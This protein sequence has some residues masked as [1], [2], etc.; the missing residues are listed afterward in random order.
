M[1]SK[2]R[3]PTGRRAHNC[4]ELANPTMV[5]QSYA[6]ANRSSDHIA[7]DKNNLK[8]TMGQSLPASSTQSDVPPCLQDI[9]ESYTMQGISTA[10]TNIIV[11]SW[12]PSTGKLYKHFIGR[13]KACCN[14]KQIDCIR[15][16]I[17]QAL[18]FLATLFE[19]GIGYS[20]INTAR[21]ALFCLIEPIDNRAF[22]CHPTV[23]RFMKGIYQ[24]RSP[25][26]R[27]DHIWDVS[28]VLD[29]LK[30]L[31]PLK[32]LTMLIALVS[33]QC[34]QSIHLLSID[35]M[36]ETNGLV[37]FTITEHIKQSRPGY[38][39]P[40]VKLQAFPE[41]PD[42]CVVS[43]L[44]E[45]LHRTVSL[46]GE[47]KQLLLSHAKPHKPVSVDTISRWIKLVLTNS[48]IDTV[49][50]KAHSTNAHFC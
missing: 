41:H 21:S 3:I 34:R 45:Y 13:W 26:P 11:N 48:G 15:P 17:K 39:P 37:V 28:V 43:T 1:H 30:T 16:A 23:T 49:T 35:N 31:A 46:R 25:K 6:V 42:L 24:L 4:P 12:R 8:A 18:D 10:A 14:L 47:P 32:G 9:R 22:G 7:M 5:L 19:S 27:Y 50:F 38:T 36:V 20:S 2:S 33:A 29:Y 44:K 40:L